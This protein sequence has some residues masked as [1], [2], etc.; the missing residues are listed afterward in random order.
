MDKCEIEE[1]MRLK[2]WS[3][4]RLAAELDLTTN[5]VYRWLNGGRV[6]GGPACILMRMWLAE[7]RR[8]ANEPLQPA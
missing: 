2:N 3:P 4:T 6:P 8:K 1:L 7:V 5:A